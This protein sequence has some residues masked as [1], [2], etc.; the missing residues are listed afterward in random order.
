[1]GGDMKRIFVVDKPFTLDEDGLAKLEEAIK[2]RAIKLVIL[3]PL[4]DY[5]PSGTNTYRDEEVRRFIMG[6]LSLLA[7]TLKVTIAAIRHFKKG[8]EDGVKYRGPGSAGYSNVARAS[9]AF[10]A[11]PEADVDAQVFVLGPNKGNWVPKPQRRY[12]RFRIL[13]TDDHIGRLDWLGVSERSIEEL[14]LQWRRKTGS[15]EGTELA[16]Q[17]LLQ[18][19][20]NGPALGELAAAA[21]G[22]AGRLQLEDGGELQLVRRS[23]HQRA[24]TEQKKSRVTNGSALLPGIDQRSACIRRCKDVIALHLADMGGA[25]NVSAAEHSIIRRAAVM[26]VELEQLEV[27]FALDQG[28]AHDIDL[29][30][31]GSGSLRR[32]LET[33]GLQRRAKDIGPT[34]GELLRDAGTKAKRAACQKDEVM[35]F[36]SFQRPSNP[37][38]NALPTGCVPTPLIPPSRWKPPTGAACGRPGAPTGYCAQS[39]APLKLPDEDWIDAVMKAVALSLPSRQ[40]EF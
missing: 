30:I 12:L 36:V 14:D 27:K 25:D 39:A 26:T 9:V 35:F 29:Y 21:G 13:E 16:K 31:R 8:R 24:A 38:S 10:I 23:R 1:M 22:G 11:D 28:N 33:I 4:S 34:L 20:A 32:L 40:D 6:P 19:V 2:R 17:W 18:A 5:T 3:D 37:P 15:G 7:R